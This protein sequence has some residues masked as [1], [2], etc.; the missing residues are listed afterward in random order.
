M[1]SPIVITTVKMETKRM[2]ITIDRN[3]MMHL[4]LV[5]MIIMRMRKGIVAQGRGKW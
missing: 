4:V 5:V 3:K 1:K 2:P